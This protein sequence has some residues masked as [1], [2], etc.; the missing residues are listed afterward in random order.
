MAAITLSHA[1][2]E[3][4][5]FLQEGE[6]LEACLDKY[7]EHR[8]TLRPLLAVAQALRDQ[9]VTAAPSAHF[10][11]ELKSKVTRASSKYRKGGE[12]DRKRH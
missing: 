7:P 4:L 9:Q 10:L 6:S 2:A 11:V 1:L 12:A 8:E 5:E 3:C